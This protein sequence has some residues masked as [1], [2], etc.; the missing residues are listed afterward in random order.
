M[1]QLTEIIILATF[2]DYRDSLGLIMFVN[3]IEANLLLGG[4]E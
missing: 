4:L 3:D 2:G 1:E